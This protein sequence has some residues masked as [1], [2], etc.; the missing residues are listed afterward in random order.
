MIA[1]VAIMN[2][3][4]AL[5]TAN[6]F[7]ELAIL[8]SDL[9]RSATRY[10]KKVDNANQA[11]QNLHLPMPVQNMVLS[12]MMSTKASQD[13]QDEFIEFAKLISPSLQAQ[14]T[15]S[16]FTLICK[17]SPLMGPEL[18]D[19]ALVEELGFIGALLQPVE[20]CPEDIVVQ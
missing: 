1:F 12:Y 19:K 17:C 10:Q 2:L 11:M 18:G 20:Q 9:G 5:V 14:I 6:L 3:S 8:V 15:R 4:G 13:S 16:L 7:G